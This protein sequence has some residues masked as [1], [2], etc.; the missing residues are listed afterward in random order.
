MKRRNR[1]F[2]LL[3]LLL[4]MLISVTIAGSLAA[5]LYIAF[6]ARASAEQAV[7]TTRAIDVAGDLLTRDIS[8]ALPPNGI[9]AGLFDGGID[10]V[11]FY[12]TGPESKTQ[13]Q[14]DCK[15]VEYALTTDTA[16]GVRLQ[17][18]ALVRRVTTNLLSPV[19]LD[20]VE[21]TT[22]RNV[23]TLAFSYFDGTNWTD[24]WD[25]TQHNNTL[26]VAIQF[27]LILLPARPDADPIQMV[28]TI[29]LAC[30][31]PDTTGI[32]GTIGG[33]Q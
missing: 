4:A 16:D 18:P 21:E 32:T 15:L 27:T 3:E 29:S 9:L 6:R 26:P 28:R 23:D 2:T 1:G 25:S 19:Q 17:Q 30:G 5:S 11:D 24:T 31:V 33:G 20:P 8:N 7:G 14:G 13:V 22:C 12:C 10:Y